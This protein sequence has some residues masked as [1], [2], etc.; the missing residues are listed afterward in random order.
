MDT[1][2]SRFG[3]LVGLTLFSLTV[4]ATAAWGQVPLINQPL[5]PASAAPGGAGFTL[6]VNGTGFT[7]QSV[8]EWNG[9]PLLTL[10][11]SSAQ[12]TASV[13]ASDIA[14]A[15]TAVVTVV[16]AGAP[17]SNPVAFPISSAQTQVGFNLTDLT[18]YE[19][20]TSVQ[21]GDFNGDGIP[22]LAV[23]ANSGI[24]IL[25]GNGDG[26][27]RTPIFTT[28]SSS[29]SLAVGDFN[30]DGKLD[31]ILS[32]YNT[33]QVFLGNGDGTFTPGA[34]YGGGSSAFTGDFNGDGKLD[35]GVTNCNYGCDLM[36]YLGNGNGTFGSAP[37]I[38]LDGDTAGVVTAADF[39]G[40]GKLDLAIPLNTSDG[41]NE[42]DV[43][44]G[45]GD[46][47]FQP[48]V[49]YPV[50]GLPQSAVT[51]DFNGDGKLD[52]VVST[53][54][55][56]VDILL[57]NGDGTFQ[58]PVSYA[59]N[60]D[61]LDVIVADLNND[62]KLD[63]ATI[64]DASSY[65]GSTPGFVSV[66]LGNGDG[67]FQA[68]TD[69]A[70]DYSPTAFSTGDFNSDGRLDLAVANNGSN[71]V[72]VLIQSF[73]SLQPAG[74]TFGD[75]S[76]NTTSPPQPVTLTNFGSSI[77]S[78][79]SITFTGEDPEDFGQTN[80]C[81]TSLPEGV[82]CTINV[83]FTPTA[84]GSLTAT[85]SVSD[86]PSGGQLASLVGT[87]INPVVVLSPSS[88]IFP[89]QLIGTLSLPMDVTLTNSGSGTLTISSITASAG[90][91][92]QNTCG[93]S[94]YPGTSCVIAVQFEPLQGGVQSGSVL[95]T[96]NTATSPQSIL[97]SGTGTAVE[98]SA[99]GVNFGNQ[100][101]GSA[102]P[103]VTVT[104]T[105][106][107]TNALTINSITLGGADPGDFGESNTCGSSVG[108]GQSCTITVT[109]TP[110]V[111]GPLSA[112]VLISD[113]DPASPQTIMLSGTGMASGPALGLSATSLIF[114]SQPVGSTT[115]ATVTLTD[116]GSAAVTFTS[117]TTSGTGFSQTNTCGSGLASGANCVVTVVFAPQQKGV[118]TGSLAIT[119]NAP[120]SPQ[121]VALQGVGASLAAS[122]TLTVD[123]DGDGKADLAVWRPSN[124]TWYVIPSGGGPNITQSQGQTGDIPVAADYDGDGKSDFAV[125]RPSNGTWYIIP[126]SDSN[127]P[128]TTPWGTS[129][130]VPVP[131]DYDGD[132]IAD[133]AVWRPSNGTWYIIPSSDPGKP[134]TQQWGESGDLPVIGD[135]DGDGKYDFA[136]WRP[137]NGTWYI[138]PSSNPSTPIITVWGQAGD[139][140]VEGDY[141][142][143]GKTDLAFL[144]PA[145]VFSNAFWNVIPSSNPNAPFSYGFGN[146]G[147][148]PAV[149]DYDG[150][151]K[152]DYAFFVSGTGQWPIVYSSTGLSN[153]PYP[154]W[155]E[156]ADTPAAHLPSTWRDKHVTNIDGDR[157]TDNGVWD[158][159]NGTWYIILSGD[160]ERTWQQWG[161]NGDLIAPGD[162]DG[163]GITDYAVW[164]ASNQTWYV[165]YSSTKRAVSQQWGLI[166]DIP[167]PGDYDGDGKTD[168]AVWRPSNGTWYVLLSSTGKSVSQ[169]WGESG[170]IPVPA[171]YD[172]DGKTDYAVWRPSNGTFYVILSSTGKTVNQQ[173]GKSGDL[174]V[175]GDYDGDSKADFTI[176]RPSTG[177]WYTL[178]SSNRKTVTTVF[179]V[180]TDIPVAKDYDGDG[181]TDVAVYRASNLTFY[182]LQSSNGE[183]M[184]I[185]QNDGAPGDVPVNK[186]TGQ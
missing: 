97:L 180:S 172:G 140:P 18:G 155:G 86:G 15:G 39:N 11:V 119:D 6:T 50:D 85:L 175:P 120:G 144:Q 115:E 102:S 128:I 183:T 185:G 5:V 62:G 93:T 1:L 87:A 42:V 178:Q 88:L 161:E 149:G 114:K 53:T 181:K 110:A 131:G 89:V 35:F 132:G 57:G 145:S 171:D 34:S 24:D 112:S 43:L 129:G 10:D 69:F 75:Q 76:L 142:G 135:Y 4:L 9:V 154:V 157:K 162:Y 133:V 100:A 60:T 126:S 136:V 116:T 104:L 137:S 123:F 3:F 121:T 173:W 92:Q 163:D 174:P 14:T 124:A 31:V 125:F 26:T 61:P 25:L 78:I 176:F 36:L 12:L 184:T 165:I 79:G 40:D 59:T 58:T 130:D 77:L 107:G 13:P 33:A 134:V 70:V 95:I 27:F 49:G 160:E 159:S 19:A 7:P 109:F 2:R 166:G 22:D 30:G 32:N 81:G 108:A 48:Q 67:T 179:G 169:Q 41:L 118:L 68:H 151:H 21:T 71:T 65:Y 80:N 143:D 164:R 72:S 37:V 29:G 51:A 103:P 170:D 158:P 91:V 84:T 66:L 182:I 23:A 8:V 38:P 156:A 99:V 177:T 148:L 153:S 127:S 98:L 82:S 101:V 20:P 94:V 167:V 16:N 44:L 111:L 186:P 28:T 150:D 74:L 146:E 52:V 106:K 138:I 122:P 54:A 17:S 105:N 64:D 55:N 96:D 117:I 63:L 56:S 141:D 113:T 152:N 83:T 139:I 168:Y 46:G 90:F 45:N 147:Y 73:A 47:T